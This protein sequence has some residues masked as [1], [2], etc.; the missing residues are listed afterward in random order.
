LQEEVRGQRSEVRGQWS[1]VSG[2][3]SVV[4]GQWSVCPLMKLVD[5]NWKIFPFVLV[6]LLV[7]IEID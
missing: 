1:V 5:V 6:T 7:N 2:Q 4:S 3:W